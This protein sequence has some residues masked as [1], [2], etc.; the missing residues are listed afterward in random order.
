MTPKQ[1]PT[2]FVRP[3]E[4][5]RAVTPGGVGVG[6]GPLALGGEGNSSAARAATARTELRVVRGN[7]ER[8]VLQA[9]GLVKAGRVAHLGGVEV[10]GVG[11]DRRGVVVVRE[12]HR[13]RTK[14]MRA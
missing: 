7:W 3:T 5:P 11:M 12:V 14:R 4:R 9:R 8:A 2:R 10:A 1:Q 6:V 13:P